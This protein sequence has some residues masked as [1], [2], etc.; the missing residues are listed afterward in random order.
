MS[1]ATTMFQTIIYIVC[2]SS[3]LLSL[4]HTTLRAIKLLPLTLLTLQLEKQLLKFPD[5]NLCQLALRR[6]PKLAELVELLLEFLL[7]HSYL[8]RS[9]LTNTK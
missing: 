1:N 7:I 6:Q 9:A 4:H 5:L 8:H 2:P 3:S